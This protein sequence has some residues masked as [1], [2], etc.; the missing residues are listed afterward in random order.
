MTRYYVS[1]DT[2]KVFMG[3]PSKASLSEI[4]SCIGLCLRCSRY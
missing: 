2:M 1:F 4:V 3:L